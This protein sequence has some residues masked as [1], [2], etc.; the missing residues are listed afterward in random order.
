MQERRAVDAHALRSIETRVGDV[1]GAG[2]IGV[3]EA[4]AESDAA[5]SEARRVHARHL[6]VRRP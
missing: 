1:A 4:D 2:E 3:E 5:W 6:Q